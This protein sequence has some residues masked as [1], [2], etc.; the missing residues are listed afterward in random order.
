M[1]IRVLSDKIVKTRKPHVC[2]FCGTRIEIGQCANAQRLADEHVQAYTLHSHIEC[3]KHA[4]K[5]LTVE[6]LDDLSEPSFS[7]E[8]ALHAEATHD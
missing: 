2:C 4:E 8:E 3:C 5:V 1:S 6:D 7:R